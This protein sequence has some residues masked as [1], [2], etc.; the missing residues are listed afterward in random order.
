MLT[1][2][3]SSKKFPIRD[4]MSG[5]FNCKWRFLWS[6]VIRCRGTYPR[7]RQNAEILGQTSCRWM[8]LADSFLNDFLEITVSLEMSLL[9]WSLKITFENSSLSVY[10]PCPAINYPSKPRSAASQRSSQGKWLM[11]ERKWNAGNNLN[12]SLRSTDAQYFLLPT[13]SD[14][15]GVWLLFFDPLSGCFYAQYA[16]RAP[17]NIKPAWIGRYF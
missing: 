3:L 10:L 1:P 7:W 13:G 12:G 4:N 11:Q 8:T 2:E 17:G 9:R 5:E 15:F 16:N 14:M 6:V